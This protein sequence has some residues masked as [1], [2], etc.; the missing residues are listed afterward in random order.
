MEP[1]PNRE[2]I[3]QRREFA[4]AF[5]QASEQLEAA[6]GIVRTK[7]LETA[8]WGWRWGRVINKM[9]GAPLGGGGDPRSS[10]ALSRE[11]VLAY[12]GELGLPTA[13]GKDGK[14]LAAERIGQLRRVA[15]RVATEEHLGE[16]LAEYGN[17]WWVGQS[18][19]SGKSGQEIRDEQNKR[20]AA[21]NAK[22]TAARPITGYSKFVPPQDWVSYLVQQGLTRGEI[23]AA[24]CVSL[25]A[26]GPEESFKLWDR[27]NRP[28]RYSEGRS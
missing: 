6:Q 5:K 13:L 14:P 22:A 10:A 18:L 17:I 1:K 2:L 8:L 9:H 24:L 20:N 28:D 12:A 11:Q 25:D 7:S 19:T 23:S 4:A 26:L 15:A 16:L 27:A 21:S 3:A